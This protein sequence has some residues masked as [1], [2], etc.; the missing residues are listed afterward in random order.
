[1]MSYLRIMTEILRVKGLKV[2]SNIQWDARSE[3]L[4][5]C[6]IKDR[7]MQINIQLYIYGTLILQLRKTSV[8]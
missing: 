4:K 3:F 6:F 5:Q 1:M 2:F 8:T 7:K